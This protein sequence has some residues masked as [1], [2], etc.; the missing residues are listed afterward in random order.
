MRLR[1]VSK[2]LHYDRTKRA[3]NQATRLKKTQTT[4]EVDWNQTVVKPSKSR[5]LWYL[6]AGTFLFFLVTVAVAFFVQVAGIDKTVSTDKITIITQGPTV[7][8]GGTVAPLTI[9]MANR[10]PVAIKNATLS[11]TYPAGTYMKDGTVQRIPREEFFFGSVKPGEVTSVDI[12]PVFYGEAGEQKELRYELEY[13]IEGSSQPIKVHKTYRV[14]LRTAPLILSQPRY[15]NPVVGKEM[16]FTISVRSNTTE[17]L[18][19]SYLQLTYPAGFVPGAAIPRPSD[20]E[21]TLWELRSLRPGEKRTIQITGVIRG[22][23]RSEEALIVRASVAPTGLLAESVLV[24]EESAIL[25]VEKA[26]LDVGLTLNNSETAIVVSPG[27]TVRGEVLWRN[28]DTA[29]LQDLAITVSLSGTGLDESSVRPQKGRFDELQKLIVWDERQERSLSLIDA[30]ESGR[31]PFSFSVL[32]DRVEFAQSEKQVRVSVSAQARRIE[33]GTAERITD[34]I[35][36]DVRLRS[37]LQVA[38]NTLYATSVIRNEGSIPPKVG[39]KTAYAL[40]YVI[41]NSG[42]ELSDIVLT[43][44]LRPESQFSGVT[45]GLQPNEW[46]HDAGT[47][48]ITVTLS[49]LTPFGTHSSRSMEFQVI[50]TP[51]VRDVGERLP[52]ADRVTYRAYDT[53]TDETFEGGTQELTTYITAEPGSW[54]DAEVVR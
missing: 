19:I 18:P 52:L 26:F 53:Y 54:E 34:I 36:R 24:A 8:D 38:A 21:G 4:V 39:E 10:N 30:R 45:A 15:T 12:T 17:V 13:Q 9:R 29:Q 22:R 32:P 48:V 37:A 7:I 51:T 2:I 25:T 42:N 47:N 41:K 1:D 49:S 46:S 5:Y 44:P 33:T 11:V 28:D 6:V 43:V 50:V 35:V 20:V 31:F 27:E 16:T 3:V 14:L 40:N 23:E